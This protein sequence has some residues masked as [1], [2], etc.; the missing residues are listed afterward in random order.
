[1]PLVPSRLVKSNLVR[2]RLV[3]V[4]LAGVDFGLVSGSGN[5]YLL[6]D[7]FTD[8]RPAGGVNGTPATPGPGTRTVTDTGTNMTVSGG[9]H[10]ANW[11]AAWGDKLSLDLTANANGRMLI[12]KTSASA[13]TAGHQV[14]WSDAGIAN[15]FLLSYQPPA[16]R[17]ITAGS[18]NAL[19][20]SYALS[21]NYTFAVVRKTAGAYFFVKGGVFTSWT[22]VWISPLSSTGTMS[23]M[24]RGN[25][26]NT[27]TDFL[28]VPSALWLPTP[29]A[30]DSF[31]RGNGALGSTEIYGPDSQGVS[32]RAWT[33][34]AGTWAIATNKA[35]CS[36]LAGGLGLATV[37]T[38]TA[39]VIADV[40][41]TR[42]AGAAGLVLRYQDADNYLYAYHDGTNAAL[43]KRVATVESNVVAPAAAAYA[44]GATLRV[45]LSGT[46]ADLFYNNA[47]V[48]AT[49]AVPASAYGVHGLYTNNTDP[50]LDNFAVYPRGTS[51][52]YSRL[53]TWSG[54]NP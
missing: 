54:A 27:T 25:A 31:G 9:N 26:A 48:G 33:D 41:V 43:I 20:F 3:P 14:G 22:L 40:A 37:P 42:T 52:E 7:E 12:A 15:Y 18:V 47:K 45:I 53:D 2:T 13:V 16:I 51:N 44:A 10:N 28:R 19:L 32:A 24:L 21:T 4:G 8:A 36:A 39:D 30:Y 17:A 23:P 11:Q 35:N 46:S 29:L 50:T 38:N 1:M 34:T 49:G 6:D 5:V